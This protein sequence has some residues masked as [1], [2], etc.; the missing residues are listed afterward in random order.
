MFLDVSCGVLCL[1]TNLLKITR[2]PVN[3]P[4]IYL[5]VAVTLNFILF[6]SFPHTGQNLWFTYDSVKDLEQLVQN[7]NP[8][9]IRESALKA[10][11]QKRYPD[12]SK[13]IFVAQR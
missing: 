10:E 11:L 5:P 3:L 13:A 8:Q 2:L 4:Y 1:R 12:A 6:F 9:G 7:L